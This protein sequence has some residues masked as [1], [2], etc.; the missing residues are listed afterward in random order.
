MPLICIGA[1]RR[2]LAYPRSR[3]WTKVSPFSTTRRQVKDPDGVHL[4]LVQAMGRGSCYRFSQDLTISHGVFPGLS[5][6]GPA[7]KRTSCE[8]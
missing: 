4:R 7:P 5:V 8:W 3:V 2:V 6:S 1:E